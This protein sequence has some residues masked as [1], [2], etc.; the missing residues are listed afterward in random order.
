MKD[1]E[2]AEYYGYEWSG[3]GDEWDADDI[4][5]LTAIENGEEVIKVFICLV[6]NTDDAFD[7]D[8]WRELSLFPTT[9]EQGKIYLDLYTGLIY[10]WSG[11][12]YI[13]ID[14]S[15]KAPIRDP[16]F[17]NSISMGRT[18]TMGADSTAIGRDVIASGLISHAEGFGT[19]A[20]GP[21]SHAE[22]ASTQATTY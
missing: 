1:T 15:E 6:D 17:I 11:S 16:N 2:E 3:E 18:G 20:T 19:R 5:Y 14:D 10:R 22:G 9:G 8:H 21:Y 4:V 12:T 7:P 13:K